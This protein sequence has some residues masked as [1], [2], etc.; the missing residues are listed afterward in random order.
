MIRASRRMDMIV[1][2]TII[3]TVLFF[4]LAPA[5]FPGF[6]RPVLTS[7]SFTYAQSSGG[8]LNVFM[9]GTVINEGTKGN[10]V[11]TLQLINAS[12]HSVRQKKSEIFYMQQGEQR[13][14]SQT[15][16][17]RVNEPYDIVVDAQRK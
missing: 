6:P 7:T 16:T 8:A 1:F 15:L 3:L 5:V 14:I 10:V 13:N 12:S 9:K 17:G 4:C 11:I 2:C